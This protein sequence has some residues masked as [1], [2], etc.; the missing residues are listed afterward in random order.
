MDCVDIP[1]Q[2][3]HV[4]DSPS[5]CLLWST[6]IAMNFAGLTRSRYSSPLLVQ[7]GPCKQIHVVLQNTCLVLIQEHTYYVSHVQVW[8][9]HNEL[10]NNAE[11]VL[12]FSKRCA[13]K[14]AYNYNSNIQ[15]MALGRPETIL[16]ILPDVFLTC[17]G[18]PPPAGPALGCLFPRK[19][20]QLM[21]EW[22]QSF[23][24]QPSN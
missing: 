16:T 24:R 11:I 15:H 8:P 7:S 20:R 19:A 14:M 1:F 3:S 17:L 18:W 6:N 5:I 21:F 12:G 10:K 9:S 2:S 4:W 23:L 22:S 13:R